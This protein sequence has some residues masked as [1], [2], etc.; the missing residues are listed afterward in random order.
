MVRNA[1]LTAKRIKALIFTAP[2]RSHCNN[3]VIK[4]VLNK[5]LKPKKRLKTS[6]LQRNK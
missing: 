1:N 5:G 6:D 3:F 4:K 2:I